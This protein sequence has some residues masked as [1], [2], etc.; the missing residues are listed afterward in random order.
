MALENF[1]FL[2]TWDPNPHY[3]T[4]FQCDMCFLLKKGKI[5]RPTTRGIN[6]RLAV[7]DVIFIPYGDHQLV[8]PFADI[9]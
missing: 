9:F 6:D 2:F 8:L 7:E 1:R 5:H 4:N 3:A